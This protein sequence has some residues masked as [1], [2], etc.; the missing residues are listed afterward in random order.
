M[1]ISISWQFVTVVA[2]IVVGL[3]II[4]LTTLKWLGKTIFRLF[5]KGK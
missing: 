1:D 5:K 2:I 4:P 3:K